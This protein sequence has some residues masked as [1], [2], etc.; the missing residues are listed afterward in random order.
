VRIAKIKKV[1]S[2]DKLK[3]L[4]GMLWLN[5]RITFFVVP[6]GN[7]VVIYGMAGIHLT[8]TPP[9]LDIEHPHIGCAHKK[10]IIKEFGFDDDV[11]IQNI[12]RH[13]L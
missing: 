13:H 6:G 1:K 9:L 2:D 7:V 3:E 4:N 11:P 12:G 5:G 10:V 8:M